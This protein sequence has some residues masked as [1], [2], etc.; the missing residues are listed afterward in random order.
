MALV[1]VPTGMVPG[2]AGYR[3]AFQGSALCDVSANA[4]DGIPPAAWCEVT[5]TPVHPGEVTPDTS[6]RTL[7]C[8]WT[9]ARPTVGRG[10]RR[11]FYPQWSPTANGPTDPIQ[12]ETDPGIFWVGSDASLAFVGGTVGEEYEVSVT[13]DVP[14]VETEYEDQIDVYE[15]AFKFRL[16]AVFAFGR[17]TSI[18]VPPFHFG[19]E[20]ISSPAQI[21]NAA[22][23]ISLG[24][25][26]LTRPV[27]L[28]LGSFQADDGAFATVGAL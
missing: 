27:P 9:F 26:P 12:V 15:P 3:Y 24:S 7:H 19:F 28:N 20:I 6:G 14:R 22:G 25:V 5:I 13:Y 10:K 11:Q 18:T 1:V 4:H 2:P 17:Y 23:T 8:L 21:V 16:T